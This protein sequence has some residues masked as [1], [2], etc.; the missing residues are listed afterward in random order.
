MATNMEWLNSNAGRAYPFKEDSALKDATNSIVLPNSLIVDLCLVAP[1]EFDVLVYLSRLVYSGTTLELALTI[2]GGAEFASVA[3]NLATHATNTGYAVI[4]TGDMSDVR[5]RICLGDLS[6][7]STQLVQGAFSFLPQ[8]TMFEARAV[9]PDLRGVRTIRI[10]KADGSIGEPLSGTVNL[11][12]G[13]NIRL[14]Y[15]P[16]TVTL[17]HG[18]RIDSL[19]TDLEEDCECEEPQVRPE[20]IRSINGVQADAGGNLLLEA[21][22]Q[23]MEIGAAAN[24]ITLKDK[25]SKPCCGCAELEFIVQQL[26]VLKTSMAT[27]ESNAAE[28]SAAEA[29]FYTNVLATLSAGV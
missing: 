24:S 5:G 17:P 10:V 2:S 28:L 23:C 7:L 22:E 26:E 1:A 11:V 3:I 13:L 27:L 14:T 16:A 29:N 21:L 6:A 25:C 19:A 20:P 8:A 4:G 12:E 15:V 9:R 18:I